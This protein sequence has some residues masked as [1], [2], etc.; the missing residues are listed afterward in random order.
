[1]HIISIYLQKFAI[2]SDIEFESSHPKYQ[3]HVQRYF[4]KPRSQA[5]VKLLGPLFDNDGLG[6][7]VSVD[8]LETAV[9]YT[10]IPMILLA[11]FVPWDYLQSLFA[12]MGITDNNYSSFC[13]VIW[14]LCYPTLD[15]HVKY[16]ITNVL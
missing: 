13:W 8:N 1:M 10:N 11:L 4:A 5:E 16:Y 7:I 9:G 6:N 2:S 14:C 3:T 15:K 12:D